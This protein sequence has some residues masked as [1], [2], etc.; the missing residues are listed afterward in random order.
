MRPIRWVG[1]LIGWPGLTVAQSAVKGSIRID[2][3]SRGVVGAQVAIEG[4]AGRTTTSNGS[5]DFLLGGIEPGRV[6]IVFRAIG[7]RP[8]RAEAVFSG[9]DTLELDVRMSPLVQQL[10]A[11]EVLATRPPVVSGKMDEF[12]RRKRAG[13]GRFFSRRELAELENGSMVNA[14]RLAAG[15]RMIVLTN[16]CGAGFALAGGR[17]TT[18]VMTPRMWCGGGPPPEACYVDIYVDGANLWRWGDGPPL[19]IEQFSVRDYQAIEVYRGRSELP[20]ELL[21]GEPACGALVLWTRTGEP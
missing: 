5:G 4:V 1:L 21:R 19:N 14:L 7:F 10:A 18:A 9:R 16:D 13:F 17:Q 8:L 15:L 11:L 20:I 2:S 3:T 6:V 12:E